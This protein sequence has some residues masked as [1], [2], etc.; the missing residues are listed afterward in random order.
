MLPSIPMK[1]IV[2]INPAVIGS[3]GTA[4]N[5]NTVL[6]SQNSI[7]PV[8]E[9]PSAEAVAEV[10]GY[11]SE[12][13][14]FAQGYFAG[15][16]GATVSPQALFIARFNTETSPAKVL[17]A[18]LKI[19]LDE[20][21]KLN[22]YIEATV[23][24]TLLRKNIAFN[25]EITSFSEA[26][27]WITPQNDPDLRCVFDPVRQAFVISVL[28]QEGKSGSI[29]AFTGTIADQL[30]LSTAAGAVVDNS[31]V[32]DT[33]ATV[34]KRVSN[35][36]LNF[37]VISFV[38]SAF[39]TDR[40]KDFALWNSRQE[41]RYW[42]VDYEQEPNALIPN[43]TKSHGAWIEENAIDGT[44][45]IYGNLT[46]AALACGY[47]ASINFEE[48][49]GNTTMEFR[50]Q[51]GVK[52]AV[53]QED[54]ATA[55]ESNGYTYYGAWA[56]ANDRFV[57]FANTRV[58]G[59]FKWA[60]GYLNQIYLNA[61]FQLAFINMLI[62]AKSI[63]YNDTGKALHRATAKDP[64]DQMINFGGIQD[65][66]ELSEQQKA[67]VNRQAGFDAASQIFLQGWC[68]LVG[69]ATAQIRQ[70]RAS[71]PLVFWYTDGSSVHK[72]NLSS[73]NIQ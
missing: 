14:Q 25:A 33:A 59:Q 19:T 30:G 28:P 13:Y 18:P 45:L 54:E 41:S 66:V 61:Q 12:E 42:F 38:G 16:I 73:I 7:Y 51:A 46:H 10:F 65:G 27:N 56:T 71:L 11:D 69:N 39:N 40:R 70:N 64:I 62:S 21:K 58:S 4:L 72:I 24:G 2:S 35:Y 3:A 23:N 55:L 5:L 57:F 47:A 60:N 26:A 36:T 44:T 22:G 63:P 52:A 29:S 49:N 68:L 8:Y 43:N 48:A 67:L 20:L 6:L 15:F 17:G 9:Y 32:A 50:R 1:R 53:T 37:A 31:V 34:M